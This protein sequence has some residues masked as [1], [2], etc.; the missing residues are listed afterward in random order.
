MK[1]SIIALLLISLLFA[2]FIS[3]QKQ[4]PTV[5]PTQGELKQFQSL[6]ESLVPE[7][8]LF[9]PSI[10][11][12]SQIA[13]EQEPIVSHLIN[14]PVIQNEKKGDETKR[15]D[16]IHAEI[17][18]EQPNFVST[19]AFE[20]WL[21]TG[22][23][24]FMDERSE[25]L[26][27]SSAEHE[28]TYIRPACDM[29]A[30]GNLEQLILLK[31]RYY[32]SYQ[33]ASDQ[34]KKVIIEQAGRLGEYFAGLLRNSAKRQFEK[35]NE[36]FYY[37]QNNNVDYYMEAGKFDMDNDVT[38]LWTQFDLEFVGIFSGYTEQEVEQLIPLLELEQVTVDLNNDHVTQ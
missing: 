33:Y 29:T 14:Q 15:A 2:F 30:I 13:A 35:G 31:P 17:R 11:S 21:K 6:E 9:Q 19:V 4:E 25:I 37:F 3:C 18:V 26:Q 1:K 38:V 27:K 23:G 16:A 28:I 24:H 22:S 7:E 12:S 10:E 32:F 20:Q 36:G 5:T 8:S 34:G